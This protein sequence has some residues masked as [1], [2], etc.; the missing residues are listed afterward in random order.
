MRGKPSKDGIQDEMRGGEGIE[1]V[2][3]EHQV[4]LKDHG[5]LFVVL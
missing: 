3:S 4:V 1:G 5:M 2:E